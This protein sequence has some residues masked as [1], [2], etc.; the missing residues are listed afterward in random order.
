MDRRSLECRIGVDLWRNRNGGAAGSR[1]L[2]GG[3]GGAR[4][5]GAGD[6]RGRDPRRAGRAG[7]E[8]RARVLRPGAARPG[9]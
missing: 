7:G 1:G 3:G 8:H 4:A 2:S 5:R 6:G 9:P